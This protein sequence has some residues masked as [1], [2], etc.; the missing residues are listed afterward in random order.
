M[1]SNKMYVYTCI[2]KKRKENKKKKT[3]SSGSLYM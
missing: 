2:K 3:T 1:R